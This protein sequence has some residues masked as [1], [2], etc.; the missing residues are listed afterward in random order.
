MPSSPAHIR[1]TVAQVAHPTDLA[2]DACNLSCLAHDFPP[3]MEAVWD[4]VRA[5]G[6]GTPRPTSTRS[7]S[8]GSRQWPS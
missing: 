5:Q 6:G 1:F 2:L 8:C 4:D 3:I 7:L